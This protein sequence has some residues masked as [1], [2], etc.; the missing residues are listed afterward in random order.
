VPTAGTQIE[1]FIR[2]RFA[3]ALGST[4]LT[5]D[6]PLFSGGIVDSFGVLEL[7]AFIE[8]TFGI[9][10]DPGRHELSDFDTISKIV[11]LLQRRADSS[12]A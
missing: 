5:P 9:D 2:S 4:A 11:A 10:I 7:L 6:T 12:R 3:R 8:R 1:E